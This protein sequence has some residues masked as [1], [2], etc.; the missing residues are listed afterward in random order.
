MD[1][2]TSDS[3]PISTQTKASIS[4]VVAVAYYVLYLLLVPVFARV[5]G[6]PR[7]KKT[8][9]FNSF[10][11]DSMSI[12]HALISFCAAAYALISTN[13]RLNSVNVLAHEAVQIHSLGYFIFDTIIEILLAD[14]LRNKLMLA[15]HA[16]C[17]IPLLYM[18]PQPCGG[19]EIAIAFFLA[20]CSNPF[21]LLRNLYKHAEWPTDTTVY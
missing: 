8:K 3:S 16:C 9:Q 13:F 17:L 15:H 18:L 20:E 1:S 6:I 19:A 14:M 10:C 12:V 5:S 11:F 4:L 21:I 7:E 2:L